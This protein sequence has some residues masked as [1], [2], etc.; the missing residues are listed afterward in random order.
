MKKTICIL[1]ASLFLIT[2]C[3]KEDEVN[4]DYAILSEDDI[5]D[6]ASG[7]MSLTSLVQEQM[8][9]YVSVAADSGKV[10]SYP[11][12]SD[13]KSTGSILSLKQ[14][15]EGWTGPDA[16]GWYT[17]H[18]EGVY[19][20]TQR[21]RCC[22]TI[23]DYEFITSYSGAD[24]SYENVYKIQ[25]AKY[26]ENGKELYK[27]YWD[28]TIANSGYSD[29]SNVH[30]KMT[31]NDWDAVNGAGVFDWY[32]GA[33]SNG[34]GTVPFYRY[35]NIISTDAGNDWLRVRISFYDG[36]IKAWSFE[37]ETPWSPVEMP[38]LHIC[39]LN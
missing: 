11:A 18:Y 7:S 26:T 34:G 10:I 27:G 16:N 23:V 15:S 35:M 8:L 37:Y 24:G 31:F 28:W 21:V 33:S 19:D 32:W 12:M 22:D 9:S 1:L 38:D 4:T 25:Y 30:W 39:S 3:K 29:I 13:K 5:E 17:N 6:I 14:T 2:S 36:N 20:Y